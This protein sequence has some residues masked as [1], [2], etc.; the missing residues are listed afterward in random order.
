MAYKNPCHQ[1]AFVRACEIASVWRLAEL[2]NGQASKPGAARFF[3]GS[4]WLYIILRLSMLAQDIR[5]TCTWKIYFPTIGRYTNLLF[6]AH[7]PDPAVSPSGVPG[8]LHSPPSL[9]ARTET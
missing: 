4:P 6:V 5:R 7:T 2:I 1:E 9:R 8:S 3:V